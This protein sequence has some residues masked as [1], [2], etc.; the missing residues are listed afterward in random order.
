MQCK[1]VAYS[2]SLEY[3]YKLANNNMKFLRASGGN[4]SLN[5]SEG[6][7]TDTF[8]QPPFYV[9]FLYDFDANAPPA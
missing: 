6:V 7:Q 1:I 8:F 3:D 9:F 4:G 5:F 2:F